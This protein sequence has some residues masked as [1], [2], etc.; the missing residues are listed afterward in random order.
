MS[1]QKHISELVSYFVSET[2]DKTKDAIPYTGSYT[3]KIFKEFN[4][5]QFNNQ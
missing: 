5:K 3:F 2:K 1:K 4:A